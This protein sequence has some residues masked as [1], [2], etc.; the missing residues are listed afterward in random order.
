MSR[1]RRNQARRA[2]GK[3][4]EEQVCERQDIP[5][6]QVLDAIEQG[7]AP[8][9]QEVTVGVV[10]E[11]LGLDPSRA[12]RMVTAAIQAGYVTRVAS[13]GDGRRIHLEL[14]PAGRC[15]A[16]QAHKFRQAYFAQALA[17]WSPEELETF[18]RMLTRFA[19]DM[20]NVTRC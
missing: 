8:G 5:H 16:G 1:M 6:V 13:Q 4:A 2:L 15:L 17:G 7:P 3:L 18:A 10:A 20:A 11:R 9:G 14:S 12:S 19:D